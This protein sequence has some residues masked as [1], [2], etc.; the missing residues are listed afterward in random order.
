MESISQISSA[1]GLTHKF[2]TLKVNLQTLEFVREVFCAKMR[3][4]SVSSSLVRAFYE[5]FTSAIKSILPSSFLKD[6]GGFDKLR[7]LIVNILEHLCFE[8]GMI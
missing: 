5:C 2:P 7:E 4:L 1:A 3:E 8:T 6:L